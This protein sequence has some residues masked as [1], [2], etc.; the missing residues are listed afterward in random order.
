MNT[1][2][3]VDIINGGGF[4]TT[5]LLGMDLGAHNQGQHTAVC[6]AMLNTCTVP[7]TMPVVIND[8]NGNLRGF[9]MWHFDSGDDRLPGP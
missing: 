6:H 7:T 4:T 8:D 3:A 5:V 1:N 9:W 2:D